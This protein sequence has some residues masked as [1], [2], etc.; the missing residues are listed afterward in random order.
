MMILEELDETDDEDI[1][2]ESVVPQRILLIEKNDDSGQM[3]VP[4]GLGAGETSNT[5]TGTCA[6]NRFG[7]LFS[8]RLSEISKNDDLIDEILLNSLSDGNGSQCQ[9]TYRRFN[10]SISEGSENNKNI[11][12]NSACEEMP[13]HMNG[14]QCNDEDE[15]NKT[16][17]SRSISSP[18]VPIIHDEIRDRSSKKSGVKCPDAHRNGNRNETKNKHSTNISDDHKDEGSHSN[19]Q[20]QADEAPTS[21]S[22]SQNN[23]V[24]NSKKNNGRENGGSST[25]LRK[26]S[27]HEADSAST[28]DNN[29]QTEHNKH[30]SKSVIIPEEIIIEIDDDS[31]SD[32]SEIVF[33]GV[34]NQTKLNLEQKLKAASRKKEEKLR[35]AKRLQDESFRKSQSNCVPREIPVTVQ[36]MQPRI[37]GTKKTSLAAG[38]PDSNGKKCCISASSKDTQKSIKRKRLN[39]LKKGDKRYM[40]FPDVDNISAINEQDRLLQ[41]SAKRVRAREEE[42]R[43]KSAYLQQMRQTNYNNDHLVS[44]I[45]HDVKTL[46]SNHWKWTN[47]WCR[48]G[49]PPRT[50]YEFVKKNYRKLSLLYHPDKANRTL[51]DNAEN[52]F[53]AI[54]EAYETISEKMRI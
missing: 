35:E 48:L 19:N 42:Q 43:R 29:N 38:L 25:C 14:K 37:N 21:F 28:F 22:I 26:V 11:K 51:Y 9:Y 30:S 8:N 18:E 45:V 33:V 2:I 1:N 20:A 12:D 47:P 49:L 44:V 13:I 15:K 7:P 5:S 16:L 31:D 34:Q 46:P 50:S 17:A 4:D 40:Q 6:S 10:I 24:K 32:E 41:E 3:Q 36:Q 39:P 52:R 53:Q 54:K 27:L 23:H